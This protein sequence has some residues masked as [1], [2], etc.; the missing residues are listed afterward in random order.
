MAI[1][2]H[3]AMPFFTTGMKWIIVGLGNPE[4]TYKHTRHNAGRAV[5]DALA[6]RYG[7]PDWEYK[8]Q[9]DALLAKGDVEGTPALFAL[10]QTYMNESGKSLHTLVK[11]HAQI[12]QVIIIADEIDL[13]LGTWRISFDRSSGGHNGLKSIEASLKTRAFIR[14]RVGISPKD[15]LGKVAKPKGEEEV[16]SFVLGKFTP[17]ERTILA[18]VAGEIC[19]ALPVILNQGYEEAMNK[20]N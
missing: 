4:P 17:D 13:P 8:K 9:S 15:E 19:T 16:L 12:A 6:L 18:S 14:I 2:L 20:F 3:G 1:L 5:L 11:D 7:F 10:P